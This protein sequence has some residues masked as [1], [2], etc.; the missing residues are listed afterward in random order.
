[1]FVKKTFENQ[2]DLNNYKFCIK[3]QSLYLY[4]LIEQILSIF[5]EK[6][7]MSKE[8]KERVT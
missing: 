6:M 7:L 2:K 8:V 3:M 1:M 5:D 4:F